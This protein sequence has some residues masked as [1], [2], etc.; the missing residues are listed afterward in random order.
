MSSL[1]GCAMLALLVLAPAVGLAEDARPTAFEGRWFVDLVCEDVKENGQLAKGYE[2]R[3]EAEVRN[4]RLTGQY[5][6]PGS[7]SSLTLVGTVAPDG[8]LELRADGQTGKS[9][10]TVGYVPQ[11]TRYGYTMEGLLSGNQGSARRRE[12]RPCSATFSRA[13]R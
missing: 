7:P 10:R 1:P 6:S 13:P 12:L 8:T 3:F 2:L 4:G 11:G 9:D 5:G